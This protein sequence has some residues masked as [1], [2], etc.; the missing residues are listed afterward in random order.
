MVDFGREKNMLV[1]AGG[2]LVGAGGYASTAMML[3]D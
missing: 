1:E 2:M 3:V